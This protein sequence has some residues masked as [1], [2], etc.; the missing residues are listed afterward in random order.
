MFLDGIKMLVTLRQQNA[1]RAN[2]RVTLVLTHS[3]LCNVA[4]K[5]Q[6]SLFLSTA[7]NRRSTRPR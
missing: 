2:A 1:R 6:L 4:K 3:R 5:L 7:I